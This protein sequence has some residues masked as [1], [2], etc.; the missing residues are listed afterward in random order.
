MR[1]RPVSRSKAMRARSKE[2]EPIEWPTGIG[3]ACTRGQTLAPTLHVADGGSCG[4]F[5]RLLREDG[6]ATM[7]AQQFFF[8]NV[9][10]LYQMKSHD[11]RNT[12][13]ASIHNNS[14]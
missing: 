4:G 14:S 8:K 12:N 1:W 9:R 7:H 13:P 11:M 10:H 3:V 5:H 2:W 6:G